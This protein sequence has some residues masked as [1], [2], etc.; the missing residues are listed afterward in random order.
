MLDYLHLPTVPGRD[1]QVFTLPSTVTNLQWSTW[2]KPRG[3]SMA[4][5]IALSGGAAGG[6]GWGNVVTTGATTGGGGGGS[7]GIS[8]VTVPLEF[9]P[10]RLFIQIGAGGLGVANG[11]GGAG[12]LSYVAIYPD[13]TAT[14]ILCLSGA[15]G[16]TGGG[17]GT[18]GVPGGAGGGSGTIA[19][20]A[21]MPLAGLGYFNLVS[22]NNG[23]PGGGSTT[24]GN[25]VIIQTN[26]C[27]STGGAGGGGR[28]SADTVGGAF[29][30]IASS[31]VSQY[32]PA[33]AAGTNLLNNGSGGSILWKPLWFYGGC[34]GGAT[35]AA[36]GVGGSGGIGAYGA[37]GGGGGGGVTGGRGG[38]GGS[39]LVIISCY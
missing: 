21:S 33:S 16:P 28:T 27:I 9:L 5:I 29:G 35:N 31:F 39:G 20:I 4:T 32:A 10:D 13:I 36:G 7:S 12:L 3:L 38:D 14:N 17:A 25:N 37:G 24:A 6:S 2:T 26:S 34:G 22:G 1:V 19:V 11:A 8:R 23:A 15:A 30:V 18:G